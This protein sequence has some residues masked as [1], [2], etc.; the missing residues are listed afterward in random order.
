[1]EKI[2]IVAFGSLIDDPGEEI[3][4]ME[5]RNERREEVETPFAVEF[6]RSSRGRA[7]APTLVPYPDGWKVKADVIV[8]HSSTLEYAKDCLWRRELNKVGQGGH[9]TAHRNPGVNTLVIQQCSLPGLPIVLAAR[10]PPNI[11][12]L[13]AERLAELAIASAKELADGR[14]GITYLID[15]KRNGVRTPLSHSYEQEILRQ[16]GT[17]TL[18]DAYKRVRR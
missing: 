6:A 9:Y 17:T 5:I 12:P 2:G 10:F 4:A 14:D 11:D 16:T 7:G 18:N 8:I 13:T 1:M 3:E 15:A